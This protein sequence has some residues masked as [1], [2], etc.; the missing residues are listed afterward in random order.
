LEID[1]DEGGGGVEL[2]E[3]HGISFLS[4]VLCG[5]QENAD[6]REGGIYKMKFAVD[7]MGKTDGSGVEFT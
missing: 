5:S 7:W 1:E 6:Q 4:G 3:G 2:C